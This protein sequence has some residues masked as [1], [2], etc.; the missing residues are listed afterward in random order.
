MDRLPLD[1][2]SENFNQAEKKL[3]KHCLRDT[4]EELRC[5]IRESDELNEADKK[6]W[7]NDLSI[8]SNAIDKL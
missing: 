3:A 8:M 4:L 1:P 6:D 2:E 5:K 7:L